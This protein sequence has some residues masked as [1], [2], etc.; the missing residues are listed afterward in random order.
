MLGRLARLQQPIEQAECLAGVAEASRIH[1]FPSRL[2]APTADDLLD[3]LVVGGFPFFDEQRQFCQFLIE[4]REVG[5][6][7]CHH[8]LHSLQ[9]DGETVCLS[10]PPDQ[11]LGQRR[12]V[13]DVPSSRFALGWPASDDQ[14][15]QIF[16]HWLKTFDQLPPDQS[17]LEE[18][19]RQLREAGATAR[20]QLDSG[21]YRLQ[22]YRG[23]VYLLPVLGDLPADSV[24][25]AP[26]ETLKL[27]GV[28]RISLQRSE[29]E[30]IWLAADEELRLGWRDG[31]ERCRLAGHKR[32]KSL[33]K[34]LQ[35]GEIPP[36]WRERVPLLYLQDE[37]LAV[38]GIGPCH[39]SRWGEE[40]QDAEAPW[41]LVWEP[42]ITTGCD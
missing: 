20:P 33:K 32:S 23:V 25:L 3:Q 15:G 21:S 22:R 6:R 13:D 29:G 1:Q 5:P 38:G 37:L 24:A 42:T 31:G 36:W 40:G 18:F 34:V 10:C 26:G 14:A 30:G 27:D 12:F 19:I 17:L 16:R 4:Q 2:L 35:E 11:P 39:S 9:P 28:G 7:E 8:P 41:D